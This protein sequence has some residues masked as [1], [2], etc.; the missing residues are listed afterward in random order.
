MISFHMIAS[1]QTVRFQNHHIYTS[2]YPAATVV[3][4]RMYTMEWAGCGQTP[5]RLKAVLSKQGLQHAYGNCTF[6]AKNMENW[7]FENFSFTKKSPQDLDNLVNLTTSKI[8]KREILFFKHTFLMVL[9][10]SSHSPVLLKFQ[11]IP[12]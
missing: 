2:W 11:K 4:S 9:Q 8:P 3:V 5:D 10:G 12:R 7:Q 6:R 1:I